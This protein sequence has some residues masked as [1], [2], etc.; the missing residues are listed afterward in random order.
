MSATRPTRGVLD[1]LEQRLHLTE[2]FAFVSH[3]LM[4]YTPVDASKPLREEMNALAARRIPHF[5]RWPM[6][7]APL[8]VV[9]FAIEVV[10]GLLLAFYYVPSPTVAFES[11]RTIVRDLPFG[12]FIHQLHAW[13]AVA[14]VVVVAVRL[15]RLFW[16]GL[17]RAPREIL[18]WS[19]VAMAWLALQ[20]DFTGQLLVWDSGTYWRAVRGMEIVFSLPVVGGF[21]SFLLGGRVITE[22]VLI[23]FYVF[24]IITFPVAFAVL[25]W[26]T[27]ATIRRVGLSSVSNPGAPTVTYREHYYS[28][29]NLMLLVFAG[30]VSAAVLAP[31]RFSMAA[32]P[33]ATPEGVRPPWYM[34]AP[35]LL[36]EKLPVPDWIIGLVLLV[37]AF[38]VLLLPV[39]AARGGEANEKRV[40]LGGVALFGVWLA[41]TIAGAFVR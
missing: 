31:F 17:W 22:N 23:R 19:A 12:W 29:A 16:D 28:L 1:W 20:A 4:V 39:W 35:W 3:F 14:L 10:T 27:Y 8:T 6:V 38:A 32:D 18:W 34:L 26:A 40:K 30:L 33:Y 9:L 41:L 37:I 24:H 5:H 13:G 36:Y 25:I 15:V 2:A 7:L 21:L 11:T